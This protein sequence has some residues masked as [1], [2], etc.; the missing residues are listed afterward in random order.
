MMSDAVTTVP[1]WHPD[2]AIGV[3]DVDREHQRLFSLI[4]AVWSAASMDSGQNDVEELIGQLV[5]YTSYHFD[6]EEELMRNIG[7]PFLA[8]HQREHEALR[9][10]VYEIRSRSKAGDAPAAT[11]LANLMAAWLK[12][13]TTTTD[14]RIGSYMR[15]FGLVA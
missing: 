8:E 6:R 1:R 5:S 14:R 13:H 9:Q 15:R 2:Y 7:Y 10:R 12:C 3:E 4:E 11:D